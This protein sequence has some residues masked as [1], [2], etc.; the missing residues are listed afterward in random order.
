MSD[1]ETW[2]PVIWWVL[3]CIAANYPKIPTEKDRQD[4]VVWIHKFSRF[5]PC[6]TCGT[7]LSEYLEKN[8]IYP[9]TASRELLERYFY[10]LH[11]EVNGRNRKAKKHTFEEVQKAFESGKPWKEFGGY[12]IKTSPRYTNIDSSQFLSHFNLD[13]NNKQKL[14]A[15]GS[16]SSSSSSSSNAVPSNG[17]LIGLIVVASVLAV[18]VIGFVAYAIVVNKKTGFLKARYRSESMDQDITR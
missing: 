1:F 15:T 16:I 3:H 6:P 10:D 7:H 18:V 17:V 11:E 5:L 13:I 9:S 4:M 8:D 2:G 12:P 14:E